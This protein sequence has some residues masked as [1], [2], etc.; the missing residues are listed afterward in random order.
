MVVVVTTIV[1]ISNYVVVYTY[2]QSLCCQLHCHPDIQATLHVIWIGK[3]YFSHVSK[4]SC[5]Y[6]EHTHNNDM[7]LHN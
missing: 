2:E 4:H 3:P 5:Q 1:S 6:F 7:H